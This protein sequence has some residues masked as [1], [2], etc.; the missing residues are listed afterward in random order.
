MDLLAQSKFVSK[1]IFRPIFFIFEIYLKL[2]V[3]TSD[4]LDCDVMWCDACNFTLDDLWEFARIC[5]TM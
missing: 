4:A 3:F 2:V 5:N 1:F